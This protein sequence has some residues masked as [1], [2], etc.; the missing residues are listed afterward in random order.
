[1]RARSHYCF[2]VFGL[3][4][5]CTSHYPGG[6]G[7]ENDAT[8]SDGSDETSIGPDSSAGA[9][10]QLQYYA[11]AGCQSCADSFCCNE[12]KACANDNFCRNYMKCA[13]ACL[14]DAGCGSAGNNCILNMCGTVGSCST[15]QNLANCVVAKPCG[16]GC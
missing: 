15:C 11:C 10:C 4:F 14:T 8:V 6:D 7:G 3:L 9:V 12:E 5:A 13:N 1:M 16:G 2:G